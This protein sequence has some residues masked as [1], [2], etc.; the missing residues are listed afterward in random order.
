MIAESHGDT[1]LAS[2]KSYR[3]RVRERGPQ[4]NSDGDSLSSINR[5]NW[6][7]LQEISGTRCIE[8]SRLLAS[9]G[10]LPHV[11]RRII[12]TV[13]HLD[14][15]FLREFVQPAGPAGVERAE[16]K[17][18]GFRRDCDPPRCG[19]GGEDVYATSV[20]PSY[21]TRLPIDKPTAEN[22]RKSRECGIGYRSTIALG[23]FANARSLIERKLYRFER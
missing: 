11:V 12:V 10:G 8:S 19:G 20:T 17:R 4:W 18:I 22:Y 21:T 23:P 15:C 1:N 13:H 7:V 6:R 14:A 3:S 16:N 2:R 5:S 9:I